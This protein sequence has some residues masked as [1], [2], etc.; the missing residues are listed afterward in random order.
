MAQ[1]RRVNEAAIELHIDME[2]LT[3]RELEDMGLIE[4]AVALSKW[5]D[6]IG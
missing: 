5:R 1:Q 3:F 2:E 6:S 4:V